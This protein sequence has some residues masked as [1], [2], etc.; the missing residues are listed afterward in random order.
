MRKLLLY[1]YKLIAKE[2]LIMLFLA[3]LALISVQKAGAQVQTLVHPGLPFTR[4]DL[5][6]LKA[7]ITRNPGCRLTTHLKVPDS[8]NL[9]M[10]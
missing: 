3:I 9:A 6:Q 8:P 1:K 4:A 10:G 2:N 5:N 7:N